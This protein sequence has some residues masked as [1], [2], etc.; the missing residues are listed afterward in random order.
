MEYKSCAFTGHRQINPKH[1]KTLPELIRRGIDYAY[2]KGCRRFL[3]GGAIGFDTAAAR[4]VIRFKI[5]H[6]DLSFVLVL[7]C[8]N[9]S[10]R[11]SHSQKEMYN[12]TL[13]QADEII[14]VSEEYTS[15]C[16]KERNRYLAENSDILLS[17]VYRQNSG[18]A[19]TV[20]MARGKCREIYNL[21]STLEREENLP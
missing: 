21:Y 12:Y 10:E 20:R 13:S 1:E 8:V 2:S 9:Q 15:E 6:G 16:M 5:S 18:A 19:Q 4:E 3:V 14:Y 17:Y 7:P 11:W